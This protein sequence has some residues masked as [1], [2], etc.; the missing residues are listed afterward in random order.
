MI[1]DFLIIVQSM[2]LIVHIQATVRKKALFASIFLPR[3]FVIASSLTHLILAHKASPDDPFVAS[4]PSTICMQITQ[5]LSIVTAC[6]GQLKPFLDRIRSDAFKLSGA[7][8]ARSNTSSGAG[9][10]KG[11]RTTNSH[12]RSRLRSKSSRHGLALDFVPEPMKKTRTRTMISVGGD[13]W[14]K[15][16][17]SSETHIIRET[18]SFA[19]V[20]ESAGRE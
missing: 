19:V 10:S 13:D 2:L 8:W 18:R 3:G 6:W 15:G 16:S 17:Q 9:A 1:T 20:E 12:S 4:A 14:D 7:D 5:S 11:D